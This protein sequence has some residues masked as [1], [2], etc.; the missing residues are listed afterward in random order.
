M[1]N[2]RYLAGRRFEYKIKRDLEKKGYFVIRASASKGLFD[3]IAIRINRDL[4]F[5]SIEFWQLKKVITH[6]QAN[7]LLRKTQKQV[8]DE[9]YYPIFTEKSKNVYRNFIDLIFEGGALTDKYGDPKLAGKITF[10]VIYTLP[11]KKKK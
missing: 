10:G 11:K 9:R 8:L 4:S 2:K 5:L 3:L 7:K 6:N 1:P